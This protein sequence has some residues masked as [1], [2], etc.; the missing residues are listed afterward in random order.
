MED[1]K[2]NGDAGGCREMDWE[3]QGDDG[4]MIDQLIRQARCII[5]GVYG[6]DFISAK[7]DFSCYHVHGNTL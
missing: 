4:E 6:L 2:T 7:L 5:A 1:E 3:D